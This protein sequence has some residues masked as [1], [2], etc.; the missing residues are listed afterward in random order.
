M[1]GA[2]WNTT[3][4]V[5]N[6]LAQHNSSLNMNVMLQSWNPILDLQST[7]QSMQVKS[8]D[9]TYYTRL[10]TLDCLLDYTYLFGNRSDVIMVSSEAPAGNNSL[11]LYGSVERG[12]WEIGWGLCGAS[13][14]FDCD[15]L[16]LASFADNTTRRLQAVKD[17]NIGG[18][19][20]D[21]CLSSQK[22]LQDLCAVDYSF[23]IMLGGFYIAS[24]MNPR[25][26]CLELMI[27][28]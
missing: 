2:A 9:D 10:D 3:A 11:L 4:V 8:V 7:I 16:D 26:E 20:I 23:A 13:N 12:T 18:Y 14:H 22:S 21:H 17:W 6:Q 15:H 5:Q 25:T 24:F 1:E 19:K 27:Y 28:I